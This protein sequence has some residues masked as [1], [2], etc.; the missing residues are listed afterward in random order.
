MLLRSLF[1]PEWGLKKLFIRTYSPDHYEMAI[2]DLPRGTRPREKMAAQGPEALTDEELVAVFLRV[3]VK[4]QSA[5]DLGR[6]LLE[7]YGSLMALGGLGVREL[8]SNHGLG[9]AKAAQLVASFEL[10]ARV[11]REKMVLKQ[12]DGPRAVFEIF[13]PQVGHLRHETLRIAL[14]DARLRI[15]R[16]LI[17]TEGSVNETV[18][19]PRDILHPVV[20]HKAY[21]FVLIHNHPSGDP[22]PSGADREMTERIARAADLLGVDFLDHI[23]IGRPAGKHEGFFSFREAGMLTA[24]S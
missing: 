16:S 22:S 21:G 6:K 20:L 23:I 10:G 11:A 18:A 4:G 8:C 19:H 2:N 13:F 24:A 9:I 12:L 3:G 7:D 15:T 17:L 1:R 14:I 5:V